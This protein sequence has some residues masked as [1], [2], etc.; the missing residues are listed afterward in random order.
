MVF[1]GLLGISTE[2]ATTS[3]RG[4]TFADRSQWVPTHRAHSLGVTLASFTFLCPIQGVDDHLQSSLE[5]G[6]LKNHLLHYLLTLCFSKDAAFCVLPVKEMQFACT[7]R[8]LQ[9]SN[10]S[11]I[12]EFIS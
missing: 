12:V 11:P 4:G 5:P 10:T 3:E 8:A 2:I 1:M 6:Y 9:V 7:R